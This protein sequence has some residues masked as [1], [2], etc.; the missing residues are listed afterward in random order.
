MLIN[1][2][3]QANGLWT[4]ENLN[5]D[6]VLE[7]HDLIWSTAKTPKEITSLAKVYKNGRKHKKHNFLKKCHVCGKE[8]KGI[9]GLGTHMGHKHKLLPSVDKFLE[10][11]NAQ[12]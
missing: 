1:L 4:V 3:K 9:G 12:I 7:F 2:I 6:Q 11:P 10:A 5:A 8:Y